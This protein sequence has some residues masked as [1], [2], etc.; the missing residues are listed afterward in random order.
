M[1]RRVSLLAMLLI[2]TGCNALYEDLRSGD[3]GQVGAP[4]ATPAVDAGPPATDAGDAEERVLARGTMEGRAG[5]VASGT[6]ELVQTPSAVEVRFQPDFMS[7]GVPGP[8]V[9]LSRRDTLGAELNEGA[10]DIDL[11]VLG[12]TSGEQTYLAPADAGDRRY[13]WVYCFP[14]RV[15]V[16]RAMLVEVP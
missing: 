13:V 16:A 4:D 6:V 2:G 8:I 12:A 9:V 11:G 7:Q 1:K 10:G 15:E 3:A 5:Y 14:F